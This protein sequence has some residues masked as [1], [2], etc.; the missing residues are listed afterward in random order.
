MQITEQC[1]KEATEILSMR[2]ELRKK[3]HSDY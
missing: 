2:N 3:V 1:L